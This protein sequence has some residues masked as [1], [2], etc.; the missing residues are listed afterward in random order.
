MTD[1]IYRRTLTICVFVYL[2]IKGIL[3]FI[4][5]LLYA[6]SRLYRQYLLNYIVDFE[7]IA[8]YS[9]RSKDG[10]QIRP[11]DLGKLRMF[12]LCVLNFCKNSVIAILSKYF[13]IFLHQIF[14]SFFTWMKFCI[15]HRNVFV[16]LIHF[17]KDTFFI[18]HLLHFLT[19]S[20]LKLLL[21]LETCK[22][23]VSIKLS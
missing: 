18:F 5:F 4:L 12:Y 16:C 19:T 13:F 15:D 3:L 22:G 23:C 21:S 6:Q 1:W 7:K 14:S 9:I 8:S 2:F 20:I 17:S 11:E 10:V